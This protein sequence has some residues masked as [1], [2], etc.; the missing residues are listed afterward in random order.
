M[1][2]LGAVLEQPDNAGVLRPVAYFSR[3]TSDAER[4]MDI[5]TLELLAVVA[6]LDKLGMWLGGAVIE[7]S[8]LIINLCFPWPA[9]AQ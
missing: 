2:G 6:A 1:D 4:R 5:R 3:R 8:G 7:L 9:H